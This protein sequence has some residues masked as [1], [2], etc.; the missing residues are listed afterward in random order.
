MT[1]RK[2][3]EAAIQIAARFGY[4]TRGVVFVII[5]SFAG[6]RVSPD[7]CVLSEAEW[8]AN[9]ATWLPSEEDRAHVASLM[10]RVVEAGRYASW[11]A[12]PSVGVNKQPANFEYIRFN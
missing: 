8:A 1:S 12:P 2:T 9:A 4:A 5:G 3:G 10:G 6:L 11:I 7:G